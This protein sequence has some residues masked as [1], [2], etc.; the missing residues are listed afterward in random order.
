SPQLTRRAPLTGIKG[1]CAFAACLLP[2]LF[3]FVVPLLF[4]LQQSFRRGLLANFD[5]S[6]WRDAFN[7]VAFA[8][9]ATLTALLLGFATILAWRWR[10]NRLRFVAMNI[11]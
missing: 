6:L 11:A 10:P 9:L 3:G 7:S 8:T 2:V 5:I 4:L 1:G